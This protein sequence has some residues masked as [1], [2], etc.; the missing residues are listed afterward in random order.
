MEL[1]KVTGKQATW[2]W[3]IPSRWLGYD[4]VDE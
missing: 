1:S 4:P 2:A 3:W